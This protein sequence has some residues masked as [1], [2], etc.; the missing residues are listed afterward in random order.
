[1]IHMIRSLPLAVLTPSCTNPDIRC[2]STRSVSDGIDWPFYDSHD[3]VAT[4]RGTDTVSH[5]PGHQLCQYPE[6]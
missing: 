6:R 3:P 4:A 5:Q 1:M 2:V